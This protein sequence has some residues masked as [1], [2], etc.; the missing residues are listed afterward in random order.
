MRSLLIFLSL[1]VLRDVVAEEE[2]FVSD[3]SYDI[4][5]YGA[6]PVQMYLSTDLVAPRLNIHAS[7]PECY[8]DGRYTFFTPRGG[9][10]AS[11]QATILDHNGHL[12]WTIGGYQQIYN[13]MVQEYN[14][15]NYLTFWAGNDAVGGHGAGHYY[16]VCEPFPR[17]SK[18]VNGKI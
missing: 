6:Y 11:P 10:T 9:A 3:Q 16:M 14:G 17:F 4:G 12:I 7:S 2:V 18:Q 5:A 8:D 13:L 1:V 15:K